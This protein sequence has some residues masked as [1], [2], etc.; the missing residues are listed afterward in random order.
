MAARSRQMGWVTIL[1]LAI[2]FQP[3][4]SKWRRGP[5]EHILLPTGVSSIDPLSP[6]TPIIIPK[7]SRWSRFTD[8]TYEVT[9]ATTIL[10]VLGVV[11]LVADYYE[12]DF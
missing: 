1:C 8:T 9:R 10:I 11:W 5:R 2:V 3:A 12:N 6:S 7:Q 4:C